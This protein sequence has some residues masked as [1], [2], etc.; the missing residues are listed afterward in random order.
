MK[1]GVRCSQK[2]GLCDLLH[3]GLAGRSRSRMALII[4]GT[5]YCVDV[6]LTYP[7]SGYEN[8]HVETVT[9][10]AVTEVRKDGSRAAITE[11]CCC[12]TTT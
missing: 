9:T 8:G 2:C 7:A 3:K 12:N 5:F 6:Q 11:G 4:T 1:D 10:V